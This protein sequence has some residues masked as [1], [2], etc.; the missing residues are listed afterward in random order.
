MK[1]LKDNND[2]CRIELL[3]HIISRIES[4]RYTVTEDKAYLLNDIKYVSDIVSK[5]IEEIKEYEAK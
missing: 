3:R 1:I 5:R 4:L 2:N